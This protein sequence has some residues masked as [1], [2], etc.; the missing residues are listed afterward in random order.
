MNAD[1]ALRVSRILAMSLLL[2]VL[3]F[4]GVVYALTG[5]GSAIDGGEGDWRFLVKVWYGVAAVLVAAWYLLLRKATY[6][7][8][9]PVSRPVTGG[10]ERVIRLL[11]IAWAMLEGAALLGVTV[12][13]LTGQRSM[14]VAAVVLMLAGMAFSFPRGEWFASFRGSGPDANRS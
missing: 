13:L 11:I 8:E 14:L 3:L 1:Q 10:P 5:S 7:T 9:S 12:A 4:A 2:G 6:H